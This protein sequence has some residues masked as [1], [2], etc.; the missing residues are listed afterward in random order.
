MVRALQV[1]VPQGESALVHGK[2]GGAHSLQ[3]PLRQHHFDL[4]AKVALIH[5]SK[6]IIT[7][8]FIDLTSKHFI[9]QIKMHGDTTRDW[10]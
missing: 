3:R 1:R 5:T 8:W 7:P 2:R 6:D 9:V 10:P 4:Q